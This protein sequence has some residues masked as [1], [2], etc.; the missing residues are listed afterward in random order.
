MVDQTRDFDTFS[1]EK[2]P[3][4]HRN[5][6][7]YQDFM[8]NSSKGQKKYRPGRRVPEIDLDP[9]EEDFDYRGN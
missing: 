5:P 4:Y 9:I 6:E 7:F 3:S 8:N 1:P 2:V